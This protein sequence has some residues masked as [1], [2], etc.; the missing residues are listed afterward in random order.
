MISQKGI[1]LDANVLLSAVFGRRIR[2]LL[3]MYEER[4][5]FYSP[6]SCLQETRKYI[7]SI[8]ERRG[9]N[10]NQALEMLESVCAMIE[11]VDADLYRELEN[12]AHERIDSRDPNDWPVVATALMLNLPIWT[13]DQ[14][15]FGTGIASWTTGRVE[16]YLKGDTFAAELFPATRVFWT[17]AAN[18]L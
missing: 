18:S 11:F 16:L 2:Q 10:A 9:I 8:A 13:D 15:F 4:V 7:P 1:V 17:D 14:D 3:D 6:T 12:D 5:A